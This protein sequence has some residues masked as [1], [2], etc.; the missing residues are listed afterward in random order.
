MVD[1]LGLEV[2]LGA[3]STSV[4]TSFDDWIGGRD[5]VSIGTNSGSRAIAFQSW[6]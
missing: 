2:E 3:V 4:Q 1:S 6:K 5:L